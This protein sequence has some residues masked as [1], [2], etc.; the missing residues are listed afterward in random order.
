MDSRV[1]L[2]FHELAD[3]PPP[4]RQRL[5]A[6]RGVAAEVRAEL[7]SLLSFDAA[8]ACPLTLCVAG[9]ARDVLDS[10][11]LP[12]GQECGP[13]RLVRLLGRGGMGAVYLAERT[14]GE[15]QQTVAIKLLGANSDRPGWRE[16]FL[17]E[18]QL[19]ASLNHPSIVRVIDAGRTADGRPFLVMEYVEGVAID[20]YASALEVRERLHLFLRVSEA[21]SHAHRRLIVHRDL[22]PSNI[23]VDASGC[24]KLL[25]FGIARLLDE[26]AH[27][28]STGERMLTPNYASPEQ[29]CGAGHA[30]ATDVYSLGAVL[31]KLLTGRSPHESETGKPSVADILAGTM[32]VPPATRF[33]SRLPS[34][35]DYIL[36]KALRPEPD[37]RYAS[38][39]AFAGDI[40]ALLAS[41]P[42]EARAG[43]AWYRTRKF[44]RRYWIPVVATAVVIA[45][46]STGLYLADRER[47]TAERRFAQLRQLSNQVFD[48]DKA[49]RDLP[50]STQARKSLVSLSLEY[51]EGLSAAARGDLDL[52]REIA[53]GYW[54]VGRIQGVRVEL[55]LGERAAAEGSLKK[56]AEF[57]D[58]VLAARPR[59]R[60][61][62]YLAAMI[63]NDRMILAADDYRY[64]DAMV[65]A[66]ESAR[67]QDAFLSLG[68]A[69]D[70]ERADA[71]VHLSNIAL[72]YLNLHRYEEAI[73]YARR[74]AELAQSIGSGRVLVDAGITAVADAWRRGDLN[75]VLRVFQDDYPV[76]QTRSY[77][78]AT[79]RRNDLFGLLMRE[80]A[81]LGGDGEVNL[82]R[83]LDAVRVIQEALDRSEEAAQGDPQDA[84]SRVQAAKSA[85]ALAGI[86]RHQDPRRALAAYD[87]ALRR[88][89]E[90]RSSLPTQRDRAL[91]LANSSYPLRSIGRVG[92]AG[93]R[94]AS[95]MAILRETK[96]YPAKRYYFDTAVYPV[97]CALADY[98][99]ETGDVRAAIATYERL[100]EGATAANSSAPD[101]LSDSFKLSSL[102]EALARL[103]RR[104][105]DPAKAE[106]IQA[107][108]LALW[109]R[110]NVRLPGNPFIRSQ[111]EAAAR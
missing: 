51:L 82:G 45:S 25:D 40:R 19:L 27:E 73:R 87:T 102:Q 18:R 12:T 77:P 68:G 97:L 43:D 31:Y 38:V 89:G 53:Q 59:D 108:R 1:R 78:T 62:L 88:L 91:A 46:L 105:G 48:L 69:R 92:E 70:S 2:L 61:A 33:N 37:E 9:A 14:D 16:R 99:A 42:V 85:I 66:Q 72:L 60:S 21:V 56:A 32:R 11:P 63:A 15:I 103:Y 104:A 47:R 7:E 23:L 74:E 107:G 22:K 28:T 17:K 8:D 100:L 75:G 20:L 49:I 39:D 6:E 64:A 50:G 30:T 96:D 80:G 13:Y 10:L 94:V 65:H 29:I 110:W 93:E 95:A 58:G 81:I 67:R 86:L 71:V 54:R 90:V 111:L 79:M 57:V 109:Q 4:D 83:P 5:L 3:L 34:D 98:Q 24:P 55:N 44:V 36:R 101:N 76:A 52:T 106:T 41:R 35:L 26:T 84:S